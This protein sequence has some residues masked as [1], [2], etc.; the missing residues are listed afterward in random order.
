MLTP[1]AAGASAAN[2]SGKVVRMSMRRG[3]GDA[4]VRERGEPGA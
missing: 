4:T 3:M 2:I 1:S